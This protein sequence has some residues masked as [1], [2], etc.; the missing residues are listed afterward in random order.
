M[1]EKI[2][3]SWSFIDSENSWWH[4]EDQN[5]DLIIAYWN[6]ETEVQADFRIEWVQLQD[7][8]VPRLKIFDDC[9]KALYMYGSEFLALLARF[10][11]RNISKDRMKQELVKIGFDDATEYK[12]NTCNKRERGV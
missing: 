11:N 7:H 4:V 6:S 5:K 3:N 1:E 8:F 2:I 10:D 12:E 9:W